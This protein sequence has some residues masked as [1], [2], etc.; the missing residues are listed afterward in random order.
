MSVEIVLYDV[1]ISSTVTEEEIVQWLVSNC[2][3]YTLELIDVSDLSYKYDTAFA[4]NFEN[5]ADATLFKLR[6]SGA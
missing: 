2:I 3:N 4:Y 1:D 6:W 5:P